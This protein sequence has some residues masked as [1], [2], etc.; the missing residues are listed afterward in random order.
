MRLLT[1]HRKELE[2]SCI[3]EGVIEDRGYQSV[4][5]N[6]DSL[7]TVRKKLRERGI[8]SQALY[9][10]EGSGL[11]MPM[12]DALGE[13]GSYQFKPRI[14]A[15]DDVKKRKIRYFSASGDRYRGFDIH[16]WN[17]EAMRSDVDLWITEGIK[18]GDSLTSLGLCA[19]SL[20]GVDAWLKEGMSS[21]EWREI[22]LRD[23]IVWLCF[24]SDWKE[25]P[26]VLRALSEA[27]KWLTN[28]GARVRYVTPQRGKGV[29]DHFAAGGTIDELKA[30]AEL[31]APGIEAESVTI[32]LGGMK[33]VKTRWLWK[34]R[35][36]Y[37]HLTALAGLGGIGKGILTAHIVAKVTR[38]EF[39]SSSENVLWLS[40]E[41]SY[42]ETIG[43][44]LVAAGAD[45]SRVKKWGLREGTWLR[46]GSFPEDIGSLAREIEKE[47]I[48]L[49]V[50]DPL[51]SYAGGNFKEGDEIGVRRFLE[52]LMEIAQKSGVA[53]LGIMHLGKN[54]QADILTRILGS[55]AY[56]NAPRSVL[57]LVPASD[58]EDEVLLGVLKKNLA[59]SSANLLFRKASIE[60]K[61]EEGVR[62]STVRMEELGETR[63][64][65][66]E[67]LSKPERK[68]ARADAK[69]WLVEY[70]GID[71][72]LRNTT[73]AEGIKAGHSERTL[74]RAAKELGI[75]R[76]RKG[77]VGEM[78]WSLPEPENVSGATSKDRTFDFTRARDRI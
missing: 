9:A 15:F 64:D 24:D 62:I 18:K 23:R 66:E 49:V 53:M 50:F 76:M 44:R 70:L 7:V 26:N 46:Q 59:P 5:W 25:N 35:I 27:G 1:I 42:E 58:T 28:R 33:F 63:E 51:K 41:D 48:S 30:S 73:I 6:A 32:D 19:L 2:A 8:S 20:S 71:T 36:P 13:N 74:T 65:L 22:A 39:G 45:L 60:V 38:G 61:T 75:G 57:G 43:P 72:K 34:D 47:D 37:G 77:F 14:P 29:D 52:P 11:L 54:T 78:Y 16:P 40:A 17:T 12:Y 68:T 67:N 31:K 69:E 4:A 21:I 56:V 3:S 55:S 10:E